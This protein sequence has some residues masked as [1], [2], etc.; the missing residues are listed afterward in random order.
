M[1]PSNRHVPVI[2]AFMSELAT[3]CW[4]TTERLLNAGKFRRSDFL[5]INTGAE[6]SLILAA[7]NSGGVHGTH[8]L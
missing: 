6:K 1:I 7:L 5:G 4:P 2:S 8:R 3:D